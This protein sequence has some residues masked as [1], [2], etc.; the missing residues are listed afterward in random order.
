MTTVAER[1]EPG[2]APHLSAATR[3]GDRHPY[4][5]VCVVL[6]AAV[7]QMVDVSIINVAVPALQSDLKAS[8]SSTQL[9]VAGYQLA[10]A[11]VL[12]VSGRLGDLIGSRR[13]FLLGMVLFTAASAAC[14]AATSPGALVAFRIVQGLASGLMYPQAYSVVQLRI[15]EEKRR[16]AFGMVAASLGLATILGPL[17]GGLFISWD[18]AGLGWR[19]I[20]YVNVPIGL[21]AVTGALLLLDNRRPPRT[22][23]MDISSAP[24]V[25]TGMFLLLFP[26]VRGRELGWPGWLLWM[27]AAGCALL[28]AFVLRQHSAERAG[29]LPLLQLGLFRDRAFTV[30]LLVIIVFF[31]GLPVYAL[32][33]TLY[34]QIGYGASAL[35]AGVATLPFALGTVV[36]SALSEKVSDRLGRFA[37]CVPSLVMAF[38]MGAL[39]WQV[40]R[41]GAELHAWSYAPM[42]LVIGFGLGLFAPV[43]VD[44]VLAGIHGRDA[45]SASGALATSQQVGGAFGVALIGMA[46]FTLVGNGALPAAD[47]ALRQARPALTAQGLPDRAVDQLSEGFRTCFHDRLTA[48]DSHTRPE[49]CRSAQQQKA[50]GGGAASGGHGGSAGHAGGAGNADKVRAELTGHVAPR[51]LSDAYGRGLRGTLLIEVGV[52]LVAALLALLLPRARRTE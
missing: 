38:G 36:A 51:A 6:V 33:F 41:A 17:I 9:V 24:L 16:Q 48:A 19:A 44:R 4:L 27:A 35:T 46:F 13:I 50:R 49:S 34:L 14:G 45:G 20:F 31:A 32:V 40:D 52:Y 10:F 15:P 18:V 28:A 3:R 29:K 47:A 21:A 26:L 5:V 12:I 8:T 43:A 11:C 25:V 42:L 22:R 2:T 23:R 39:A 7:V 1:D 37:L 30:G